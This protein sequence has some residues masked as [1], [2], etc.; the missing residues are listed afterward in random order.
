[1]VS[2]YTYKSQFQDKL[3]PF[4]QV[5]Q[6]LGVTAN[7]VTVFA[8]FISVL[9]AVVVYF[10]GVRLMYGVFLLIPLWM[11]LRMALNAIDGMLAREF[12]QKSALGAYLNELCDV[13]SDVALYACFLSLPILNPYLLLVVI[14]L[15]VLSEY[16]GVVASLIG[17]ERRYD[18]PMG[19]SDRAFLFGVLGVIVGIWPWFKE[20]TFKIDWIWLYVP[21]FIL[22]ICLLLLFLTIYHRVYNGVVLYKDK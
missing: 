8:A 20:Q 17:L 3:R 9:L 21:N 5:L 18:G 1:M 4:V 6:R 16:A 22:S 2:I 19:K 7:Q 11:F 13:I 14:F 10:S 12:A 15:A